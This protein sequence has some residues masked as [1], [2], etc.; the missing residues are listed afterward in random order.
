MSEELQENFT[1]SPADRAG[2]RVQRQP[3]SLDNVRR[4]REIAI[5]SHVF[6]AQA[7]SLRKIN[8]PDVMIE[9]SIKFCEHML[10]VVARETVKDLSLMG[11]SDSP[12]YDFFF[13]YFM[14]FE[15]GSDQLQKVFPSAGFS[16]GD[17]E[18]FD[19][20]VKKGVRY[21]EMKGLDQAQKEPLEASIRKQ[22]M[23]DELAQIF[24]EHYVNEEHEAYLSTEDFIRAIEVHI[25]WMCQEE[26]RMLPIIRSLMEEKKCLI[27]HAIDQGRLPLDGALVE[28]KI[29]QTEVAILDPISRVYNRVSGDYSNVRHEMRFYV[30]E[31]ENILPSTV[32]HEMLHAVSGQTNKLD[33]EG[34]FFVNE[35]HGLGYFGR[36][37]WLDEAVTEYLTHDI[38][39]FE[40]HGAYLL[41][42]KILNHIMRSGVSRE[43]ILKAYFEEYTD[44]TD[45]SP[46]LT[47]MA[48]AFFSE[49]KRIF[50]TP[51]IADIEA[52]LSRDGDRSRSKQEWL[53]V[54]KNRLREL[55]RAWEH[56][57]DAFPLK[58]HAW[59]MRR[60]ETL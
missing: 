28:E 39:T 13:R 53:R 27:L 4:W 6:G 42:R 16:L 43:C 3:F 29:R 21:A 36:F 60:S 18:E 19:R 48:R 5:G 32:L 9:P 2:A 24:V 37:L 25:K 57:G 22:L 10:S 49:V 20:I 23:A 7:V 12:A 17:D 55:L 56:H 26:K 11:L 45:R 31:S 30:G 59:V 34:G 47:P 58:L 54:N 44:P 1:S 8:A 50:G 14:T 15:P 35:R 52:Y 33:D 38:D 41:E 51:L 46:R 40:D